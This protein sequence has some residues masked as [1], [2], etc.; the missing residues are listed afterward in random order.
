MRFLDEQGRKI[1]VQ[2]E[3]NEDKDELEELAQVTGNFGSLEAAHGFAQYILS[4]EVPSHIASI[5]Y[6]HF[7]A[8]ETTD[9]ANR[10]DYTT[11]NL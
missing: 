10:I 4:N 11:V 9:Q 7:Y 6:V 1:T 5:C 3:Y 2:T 8:G